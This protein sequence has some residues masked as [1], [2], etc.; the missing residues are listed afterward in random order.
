MDETDKDMRL[1]F[2]GVT[3]KNVKT[4]IE[5]SKETRELV[6]ELAEKIQRVE[7]NFLAIQENLNQFR[8]QLAGVQTKL[9][10]GGSS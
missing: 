5:H 4:V 1:H 2:E 6:I 10:S 3:A 9:Y 8:I 7:N